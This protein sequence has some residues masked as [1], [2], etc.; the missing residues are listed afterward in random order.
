MYKDD[1]DGGAA[2]AAARLT[3]PRRLGPG[4]G[5]AMF[6]SESMRGQPGCQV[7]PVRA[8]T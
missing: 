4:P 1:V 6:S 7:S 5:R 8:R 3:R 2:G